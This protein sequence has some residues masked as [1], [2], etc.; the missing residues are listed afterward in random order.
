M[1]LHLAKKTICDLN[2]NIFG[3]MGSINLLLFRQTVFKAL[4]PH[5]LFTSERKLCS[6]LPILK[7]VRPSV[8][9]LIICKENDNKTM[10]LS[11]HKSSLA[12]QKLLKGNPQ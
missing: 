10:N 8:V 7:S 6:V 12:K 2:H 1:F 4:V 11:E 9:I 3:W 5:R